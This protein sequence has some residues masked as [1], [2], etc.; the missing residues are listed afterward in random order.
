MTWQALSA[1][2]YRLL[3]PPL[4]GRQLRPQVHVLVLGPQRLAA[5]SFRKST[6]T[7][8]SVPYLRGECA[9]RRVEE[10]VE[11][12]EEEEEEEEQEEQEEEQEEEE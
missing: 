8:R 4:H 3:P 1:T 9:Y 7:D 10:V 6:R 5:G 12:E 11:E 2:P